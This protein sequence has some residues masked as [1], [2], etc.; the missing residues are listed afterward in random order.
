MEDNLQV[1]DESL[2]EGKWSERTELMA[3]GN[4]LVETEEKVETELSVENY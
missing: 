2:M 1:D 4:M 3:T